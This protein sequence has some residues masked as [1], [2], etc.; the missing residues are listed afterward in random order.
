[1]QTIG[2]R[3]N[4]FIRTYF[5][6]EIG[7]S[8]DRIHFYNDN[9]IIATSDRAWLS[10]C[11]EFRDVSLYDIQDIRISK[12]LKTHK[13]NYNLEKAMANKCHFV[14][15]NTK[16]SNWDDLSCDLYLYVSSDEDTEADFKFISSEEYRDLN[17]YSNNFT[18]T[19][20]H[21][22]HVVIKALHGGKCRALDPKEVENIYINDHTH[23]E[24]IELE[25]ENKLLE[26]T[27]KVIEKLG[28]Y[29]NKDEVGKI[30]NAFEL[31]QRNETLLEQ[32]LKH[33]EANE[34]YLH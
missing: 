29:I 18:A 17:G 3:P 13:A 21:F 24:K 32:G 4:S 33:I 14:I 19:L 31:V 15:N 6:E 11:P 1:M 25:K 12:E 27:Y 16:K 2:S 5:I 22:N 7:R 34:R 28:I 23:N 8:V 26:D 9:G 10:A 30:L 20:M